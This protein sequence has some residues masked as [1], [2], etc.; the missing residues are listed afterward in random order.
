VTHSETDC[1]LSAHHVTL[2]YRD[3]V[4]IENLTVQI[5]PGSMTVIVGANAS[6]KSTLLKALGRLISPTAGTVMLDGADIRSSPTKTTAR[7]VGL[8]PQHPIAPEGITVADLV[9][10]GRYPHQRLLS[11]WRHEDYVALDAALV[12]TQIQ[13][14]AERRVEELSGGQRQRVW[15]AMALAQETPIL[16]L[17]EPTSYLDVAHQVEVLDLLVDLKQRNGTT[18][19]VVLHDLNLACRYADVLIAMRSGR[20]QAVGNPSDIVT[21]ELVADVFG[22]QSHIAADPITGS[23]LVVPIGRHHRL[24]NPTASQH[25]E[26]K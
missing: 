14:L 1:R 19:V 24:A 12:A 9:G 15:I 26:H 20:I 2:A 7:T 17:D 25:P 11:P 6:G 4:V 10:R 23:P 18:I 22:L 8:L 21:H 13:D 3:R 5:K 16:L